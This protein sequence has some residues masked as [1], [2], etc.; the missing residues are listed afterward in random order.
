MDYV[1]CCCFYVRKETVRIC[2]AIVAF[3]LLSV[4]STIISLYVTPYKGDLKL[5]I[6]FGLIVSSIVF[7]CM[8]CIVVVCEKIPSMY[9]DYRNERYTSIEVRTSRDDV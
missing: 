8:G 2:I 6:M 3:F 1:K 4:F 5:S 9:I 7:L